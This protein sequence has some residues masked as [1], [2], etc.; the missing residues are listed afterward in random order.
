MLNKTV[1][2]SIIIFLAFTNNAMAFAE[3]QTEGQP[4]YIGQFFDVPVPLGNYYFAKSALMVFGNRWGIQPRTGEEL[5]DIIWENL[6][7]SFEAYR[8]NISV[9]QDEIDA[10]VSAALKAENVAFNWKKDTEAYKKWVKEK[11]NEPVEAFENQI[12][13]L[14]E[15]D[16]LRRQ[17]VDSIEPQVQ[18]KEAY[19]AFLDEE[20]S[21]DLELVLFEQEKYAQE[22]YARVKKEPKLWEEEKSKNPDG[23]KRPGFVTLIFLADIWKI[24]KDELYKMMKTNPGDIYAPV[25][26]YQGY[27]VFKILAKKPADESDYA[28]VKYSYYDKVATRKKYEGLNEWIRRFKQQAN[29]KIY[30]KGG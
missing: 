8:R 24:P 14:L 21:I 2:L 1:F 18:D 4:V 25:A 16:K 20:N 3:E 11:T 17:I 26:I 6:L 7:L 28:K 23:F 12:R 29:I 13:Y 30:K 22:F 10:E 27:G 15:I 9:T 5:E 19:Q